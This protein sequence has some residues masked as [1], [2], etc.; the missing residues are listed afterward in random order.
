[1]SGKGFLGL[2]IGL[3]GLRASL[4]GQRGALLGQ[5]REQVEC[6]RLALPDLT[7]RL[8]ALVRDLMRDVGPCGV[9]AMAVCAFGPAPVLLT[10]AGE[11]V[12]RIDMRPDATTAATGDDLRA[13]VAACRATRPDALGRAAM[14]ADLT[15]Y[16][17]GE[18]TGQVVIDPGTRADFVA[19]GIGAWLA[20]PPEMPADAIC[21]GL[22]AQ[23]A[24]RMG[25]PAG[26]PVVAG[27]YDSSADLLAAGF[28]SLRPACLVVGTT[29]VL[30]R[31]TAEPVRD[32][33]LRSVSH[34]GPG[35]FSGG[36]TNAAGASLELAGRWLGPARAEAP[37][38]ATPLVLPFFCGERAPIWNAAASGAVLGLTSTMSADDLHRGFAEGVALSALDIADRLACEIGPA[39]GWFAS[40]GGI[41]SSGLMQALSDALGAPVALPDP[42]EA[43]LGPAYLAARAAGVTLVLAERSVLSPCKVSTNRF[44][45]RLAPYRAAQAALTSLYAAL[46]EPDSQMTG[47]CA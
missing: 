22:R 3:S 33:A 18:L 38:A 29:L 5:R 20:L 21:G 24:A 26:T 42:V 12:L 35:W 13:R 30:G 34:A 17:A 37:G 45:R 47:E 9:D 32:P 1:M 19:A 4:V 46:R 14:A 25:L 23:V 15:G 6:D 43:G 41:R 10:A 39:A 28:G 31:L 2:D 8:E 44:R 11:P 36:W 16:L 27:C 40:G 7:A